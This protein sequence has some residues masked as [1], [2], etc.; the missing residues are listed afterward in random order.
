MRWYPCAKDTPDLAV[1]HLVLAFTLNFRSP[2]A[3]QTL[4]RKTLSKLIGPVGDVGE[5]IENA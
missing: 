4:L 5:K 1:P 3:Q 2:K